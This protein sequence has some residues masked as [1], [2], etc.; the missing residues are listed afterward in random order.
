MSDLDRIIHEPARLRIATLLS[1]VERADFSFLLSVLGL[2]KGNLSSHI[3]RLE[4]G[5][6]VEVRKSFNGRIPHTDYRLTPKGRDAL[7]QYW[8]E[9]D[10]IRNTRPSAGDAPNDPGA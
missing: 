10:R 9:L 6:Y 7:D 1:G 8:T 5:G 4:Q 2:S 3:D